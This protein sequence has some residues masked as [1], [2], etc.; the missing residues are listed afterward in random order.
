MRRNQDS[1]RKE[2]D[3]VKSGSKRRGEQQRIRWT[4]SVIKGTKKTVEDMQEIVL[5]RRAW[6]DLKSRA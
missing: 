2:Y 5:D 1:L 3:P 6:R 4:D